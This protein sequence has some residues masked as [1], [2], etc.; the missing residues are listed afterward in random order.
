MLERIRIFEQEKFIIRM[1]ETTMF[2]TKSLY[3][4]RIEEKNL[5]ILLQQED[6]LFYLTYGPAI[7]IIRV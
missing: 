1:I 3:N 4:N 5:N 6:T 2:Y 7:I